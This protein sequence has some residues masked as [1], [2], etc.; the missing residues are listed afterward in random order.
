MS[1]PLFEYAR[2]HLKRVHTVCTNCNHFKCPVCN[3]GEVEIY[4]DGLGFMCDNYYSHGGSG[5]P[6]TGDS[7]EELRP[8]VDEGYLAV[9]WDDIKPAVEKFA[10]KQ[11]I[12][13][14]I[15]CLKV[16]N[17]ID[18]KITNTKRSGDE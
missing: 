4:E 14:K 10:H 9:Y 13:I 5:C 2:K 3:D 15:A 8:Y 12:E 16:V 7:I 6:V 11:S 1:K 17:F 18:K